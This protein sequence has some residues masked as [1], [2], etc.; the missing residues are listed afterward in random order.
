MSASNRMIVS[1]L[2]VAALAIAFWMLL[3]GPKREEASKLSAEEGQLRVALSE[4]QAKLATAEEAKREFPRDYRQMVA[5]GQAAPAGD[6]TAS[7]LVE[8]NRIADSADVKFESFMLSTSGEGGEVAPP[9][10]PESPA[11]T[12]PPSGAVPASATVPPTEVAASV[13]PLGAS[14]G[15]AGLAVMPYSLTFTGDFFE[16]ADF[17]KGIDSLVDTGE[18]TLT[19]DGRLVTLDGFALSL[20]D[21]NNQ[22]QLNAS[23]AVTTYL[24]PPSQGVTG[25]ATPTEPAPSAATP[26]AATTE[27]PT[28]TTEATPGS[29]AQ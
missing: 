5:L 18:A 6:E 7:L 19:V 10:T 17:I 29:D 12:E 8:L 24:T 2:A 14:V 20:T 25:G 1:I 11:T 26:T 3:L 21:G 13:T 16:V 27:A 22:T 9:A 4:T 15:P 28:S 23:F